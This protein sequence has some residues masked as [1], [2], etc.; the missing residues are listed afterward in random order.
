MLSW[1]FLCNF[2]PSSTNSYGGF[3]SH[4]GTP[5]W[6]ICFF[7]FSMKETIQL[8]G[9]PSS[10]LA[11][12]LGKS[13]WFTFTS[14]WFGDITRPFCFGTLFCLGMSSSSQVTKSIEIIF[15]R[16]LARNHQPV[17]WPHGHGA[18]APR[19]GHGWQQYGRPTGQM[20]ILH[21][22]SQ[23]SNYHRLTISRLHAILI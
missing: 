18:M 22:E 5:R 23:C 2:P 7:G 6:A 19:R 8:L 11:Y 1:W 4:V 10:L 15:F 9:Y 20:V 13:S 16:G 14:P 21:I 12:P 3:P 17:T